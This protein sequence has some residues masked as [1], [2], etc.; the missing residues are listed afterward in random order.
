MN[1]VE[2]IM[3]TMRRIHAF[4]ALESLSLIPF[5]YKLHVV[6]DG[7]SWADAI[8]IGLSHTKKESD[9]ILMDDDVIL[10]DDTF[11]LIG[12]YYDKADIFGFLLVYPDGKIQHA[13]GKVD[14]NKRMFHMGYGE[15]TGVNGYG[16]PYYVCHATTSLITSSPTPLMS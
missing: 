3:P 14:P 5:N 13:G 10:Q 16:K 8:N 9:I 1:N 11:N 12:E 7:S 15:L 6:T 4:K 2:I